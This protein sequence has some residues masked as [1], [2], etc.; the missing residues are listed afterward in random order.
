MGLEFLKPLVDDMVRDDPSKRPTMEQAVERFDSIRQY[1][2]TWKLR[3]R[4]IDKDEGPFEHL[5]R[6]AAHWK[7]RIGFIAKRVP[8]TPRLSAYTAAHL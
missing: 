2:S 5:Y 8:A 1:L 3:S 7:R 6:G 4:V